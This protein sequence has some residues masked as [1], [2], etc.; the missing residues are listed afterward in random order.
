MTEKPVVVIG[1]GWSALGSV[2]LLAHEGRPV[3]WIPGTAARML[4][5]LPTLD[6][7]EGDRGAEGWRLLASSLGVDCGEIETGSFLREFRN[8]SFREPVW[9]K[10]PTP[11]DRAEVRDENLW[12][13]ERAFAPAFEGRFVATLGEIEE[14][15]R[16]RLVDASHP[17]VRRLEGVPVN[18]FRI[19]SGQ[20]EAVILG[21]G[22]EVECS[23][24]IYADRW[25]GLGALCGL[26]KTLAFSKGRRPVGILQALLTH[27]QPVARGL[28]EGFF[29][30]LHREAGEQ[31]DRSVWGY[32]SS[33]G[34]R[35][36]W[37]LC[38]TPEEVEDNHEIAK[39]LRR[40]KAALGRMFVGNPWV[41]E[42][43]NGFLDNVSEEVVL[44][45]ESMIFSSGE[46]LQEPIHLPKTRGLS[47]LTDGYG[48]TRA[49]H[50]VMGLL[51]DSKTESHCVDSE[52]SLA[53]ADSSS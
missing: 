51:A 24:V 44:F 4:S 5:P 10:A 40:M 12:A 31:H 25:S 35:S 53:K 20:V 18:G 33:D 29:G 39:R 45:C 50:Q 8:K 30:P 23:E 28:Q 37:T 41:P 7:T 46:I 43:K 48:P 26:P 14:A 27:E 17:G 15:I 6:A 36:C 19:H 47:F 34:R 22:A 11:V 49:L 3:C 2:G 13:P 9:T 16:A 21:S 52:T 32:F 42:G 38:L 1:N